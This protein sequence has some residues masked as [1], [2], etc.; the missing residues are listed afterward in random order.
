MSF[1]KT[2]APTLANRERNND[3]IVCQ[4]FVQSTRMYTS[5]STKDDYAQFILSDLEGSDTCNEL[6]YSDCCTYL[7]LDCPLQLSELGYD[8]VTAFV[9]SFNDFIIRGYQTHLG[10]VISK[11]QIL[12][13]TS[14]RPEK[15]S[16][17]I[18]VKTPEFS[19]HKN[20]IKSGLKSFIKL[21]ANETLDIPGFHYLSEKPF[22]TNEIQMFS[23]IDQSIYHINRCFRS[24]HCTKPK[25]NV[26]FQPLRHGKLVPVSHSMIVSYLVTETE[27][28]SPYK[29]ITEIKQIPKTTGLKRA[30]L[31]RLAQKYGSK[32]SKVSGSLIQLRNLEKT[33]T[34]VISGEKNVSD[35]SFMIRKNGC[36]YYGCFNEA[37][38]GKLKMI[39]QFAST[40]QYYDDYQKILKMPIEERTLNLVHEY[41][42]NAVVLCDVP[43]SHFYITS[44]QIPCKAF[45]ELKSKEILSSPKL[46]SG[47]SNVKTLGASG[48]DISFSEELSRISQHRSMTIKSGTEWVPHLLDGPQPNLHTEK[49]NTFSGFCLD[50]DIPTTINFE[51]TAIF[52]LLQRLTNFHE[53]SFQYLCS[54]VSRKLNFPFR[55]MPISL[56]WIKTKQGCG[57]GSLAR[58][59]EALFSCNAN[60]LISWNRMSQFTSQFNSEIQHALWLVLE[61]VTCQN[62]NSLR[63]FSGLLR[64]V[65]S[66]TSCVL[67]KKG[68][69]RTVCQN[70]A[71][72]VIFSNQLRVLNV[73]RDCRRVCVFE[74]NNEKTNNKE[75]FDKVH[76]EISNLDTMKAAFNWFRDRD[77]T[78]FDYRKYPKTKLLERLKNCSDDLDH[79]F[80]KYLFTEHFVGRSE[81]AFNAQGLYQAWQL[82]VEL[83]GLTCKRD[84]GWMQSCFDDTVTLRFENDWYRVTHAETVKI[85]KKYS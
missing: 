36:L 77:T 51:K 43:G 52:E 31:D 44:R 53:E 15:T 33:R 74:V 64:D 1:T 8:S 5:F 14:C 82:F 20:C 25:N 41:L 61:E 26:R 49:Y 50:Q 67:E 37:C 72:V 58:F 59:L 68:Q 40:F 45:P 55:K 62:K 78:G 83:R 47:N 79:K 11:H 7:D 29:L 23:L 24:L 21:L 10:I 48:D 85:L 17:H 76:A 22:G 35:N 18:I 70:Y 9:D 57:K 80:V 2:Q 60:V 13:S 54:F 30:L 34:C 4:T 69:D 39:H 16:F 65:T 63:E 27:K 84:L 12:W 73:S 38:Q 66:Q 71:N 56:C 81:Y 42:R 75:F 32:V 19:W 28:K 3:E 46:F 6:I